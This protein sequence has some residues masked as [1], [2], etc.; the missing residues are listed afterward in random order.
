MGLNRPRFARPHLGTLTLGNP[1]FYDA[2]ATTA[3]AALSAAG[4]ISC[5][6]FAARLNQGRLMMRL[7]FRAL[8]SRFTASNLLPVLVLSLLAYRALSAETVK[9]RISKVKPT[10]PKDCTE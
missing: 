3:L 9:E 2:S 1:G 8:L 6:F 10:Q 5:P 7:R 4:S